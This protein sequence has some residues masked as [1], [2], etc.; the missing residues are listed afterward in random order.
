[1][2]VLV[3]SSVWVSAFL[4]PKGK[5]AELLKLWKNGAFQN[6]CSTKILLEVELALHAPRIF[7]KY[8]LQAAEIDK[9]IELLA[10]QSL[11][12]SPPGAVRFCRDPH[13]DHLL[14]A[15][16]LAK[17]GCI[18]TRDDDLK[19]DPKLIG[20]LLSFGMEILS[21]RQMLRLLSSE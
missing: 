20:L 21:V 9:Y 3:D 5:P 11:L 16:L 1:V 4:T 19:R 6:V 8:R 17:A 10:G 12:V 15:A 14:E 7:L 18:A 2:I 13:D